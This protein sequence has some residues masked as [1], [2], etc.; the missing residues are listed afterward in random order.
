MLPASADVKMVVE[1]CFSGE[2]APK[3]GRKLSLRA[4]ANARAPPSWLNSS[5]TAAEGKDGDVEQ[6]ALVYLF[7]VVPMLMDTLSVLHPHDPTIVETFA[8]ICGDMSKGLKR[9]GV[10]SAIDNV[11]APFLR[12]LEEAWESFQKSLS[13]EMPVFA[14]IWAK[15]KLEPSVAGYLAQAIAPV[16]PTKPPSNPSGGGAGISESALLSKVLRKLEAQGVIKKPGTQ[17]GTTPQRELTEEEKALIGPK[18]EGA[19][20]NWERNRL[21]R[22][23]AKGAEAGSAATSRAASRATSPTPDDE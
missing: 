22:L 18:P 17:P 8:L 14:S 6:S 4:I 13:A 10:A 11:M 23:K 9:N 1:A 21:K 2:L 19:G 16:S 5:S 20:K 15:V 12:E 7:T 3:E